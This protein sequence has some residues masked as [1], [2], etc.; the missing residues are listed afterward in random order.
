MP[1]SPRA[2]SPPTAAP[3]IIRHTGPKDQALLRLT[4]PSRDDSDPV[5]T[6]TLGLLE[7]IVR[8][9]LTE[10]LREKLGKAYSPSA[11]SN[12]SRYW[13][14]YGVFGL[15]ASVDVAQVPAARAAIAET[16]ARL[17]D[18]PIGADELQRARQPMIEAQDNALKSNR[19]WMALT[20]RAQSEA[21][22]IERF[23]KA[24]E[25]LLALTAKDIQTVAARYLGRANAVEVLVLPEGVDEPKP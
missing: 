5:E 3:R 23:G 9:E 13:K 20:A 18:A 11:T 15:T 22:R 4:W 14:G 12:T 10:T 2:L 8:I 21:D 17:R 19:G 1:N 7:R 6:I 24:K 16:I 25:R